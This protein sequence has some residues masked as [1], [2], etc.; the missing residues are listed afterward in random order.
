MR[1]AAGVWVVLLLG[2]CAA[3]QIALAQQ[4]ATLSLVQARQIALSNRPLVR[5]GELSVAAAPQHPSQVKS[6][7]YPQPSASLSA[8]DA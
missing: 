3:T 7:R 1:H 5:A 2:L 4:P 6:A 8:V